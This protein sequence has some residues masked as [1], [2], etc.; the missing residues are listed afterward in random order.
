MPIT[1]DNETQ[2]T[3][4]QPKAPPPHDPGGTSD[5]PSKNPDF[6]GTESTD[7]GTSGTTTGK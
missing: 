1:K 4:T 5:L 3:T 6:P 2:A 7:P